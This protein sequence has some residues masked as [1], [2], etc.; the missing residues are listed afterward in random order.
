MKIKD[1]LE[2][3]EV[4]LYHLMLAPMMG[5]VF[6][7][8]LPAIGIVMTLKLIGEKSYEYM[9]ELSLKSY[10]MSWNPIE[11][12]LTGRKKNKKS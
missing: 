11:S 1:M 8:F 2:P 3:K 7:V 4:K 9:K 5:L 6:A 10:N 12:Y